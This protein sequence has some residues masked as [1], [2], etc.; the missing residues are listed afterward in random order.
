[1]LDEAS[2]ARATRSPLHGARGPRHLAS[3]PV[4]RVAQGLAVAGPEVDSASALVRPSAPE[5]GVSLGIALRGWILFVRAP[6]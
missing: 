2:V 5:G 3:G 6:L 1:M 4:P